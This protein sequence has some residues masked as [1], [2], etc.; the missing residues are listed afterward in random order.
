MEIFL[1]ANS[2]SKNLN[3]FFEEDKKPLLNNNALQKKDEGMN[4]YDCV[5][6]ETL[7][8]VDT[9]YESPQHSIGESKPT[10]KGQ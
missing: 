2:P 7:F 8:E 9:G 3:V 4:F 10:G 1:Y 6:R 5:Q